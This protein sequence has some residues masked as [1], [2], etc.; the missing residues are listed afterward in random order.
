MGFRVDERTVSRYLP[1]GR[2]S[3]DQL[4]R[5]LVFLRN[6]RDSLVGMDFLTVPTATFGLLWVFVVLHHER[7]RILHFGVT[8]HPDASW[9][10]Q[11]LREAFPFGTA[12]R[13]AILD[14]DGK[15]GHASLWL[16]KPWA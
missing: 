10:T 13:Y 3:P 11:Q 7:R 5:W 14:R 15:Y 12:P 2:T 6:H 16:C 1:R 9:I 4:Q 8:D